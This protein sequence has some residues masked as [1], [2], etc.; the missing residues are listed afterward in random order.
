MTINL[1]GPIYGP[2]G[3][4]K[5]NRQLVKALAD[6]GM[7]ISTT[8][9]DKPPD[10][11]GHM[12]EE[13]IKLF[14]RLSASAKAD[15]LIFSHIPN[16]AM[17]GRGRRILYTMT[18]V[19]KLAKSFFRAFGAMNEIWTPTEWNKA[20]FD[21]GDTKKPVNI[22]PI[23]ISEQYFQDNGNRY[24]NPVPGRFNVLFH[25]SWTV[26]KGIIPLV[27]AIT[28]LNGNVHCHILSRP[29]RYYGA[30]A[31]KKIA[32]DIASWGGNP[33]FFS[34]ITDV[35]PEAHMPGVYRSVDAFVLPTLGE[36]WC[37]PVFEAGACNVP[38]ITTNCTA[39]TSNL[40]SNYAWLIEPDGT[41]PCDVTGMHRLSSYY[42]KKGPVPKITSE[43]IARTIFDC[44]NNPDASAAKSTLFYRQCQEYLPENVAKIAIKYLEN[45]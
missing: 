12:T 37:L 4:A 40:N 32:E 42:E 26:R 1:Q 38:V 5:M 22:L 7:P 3:Y 30:Q 19:E 44:A 39:M 2:Q 45:Q 29:K 16:V 28:L 6:H 14:R 41:V 15:T 13:E 10:A 27:Q 8:S 18:E 23:S 36:G 35:I 21:A 17:P 20:V 43:S 11:Y 24:L 31:H 33:D 9:L 34:I 25:G